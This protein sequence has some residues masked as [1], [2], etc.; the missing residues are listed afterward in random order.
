V[1][2]RSLSGDVFFDLRDLTS[3]T[4]DN[5]ISITIPAVTIPTIHT[6][7]NSGNGIIGGSLMYLAFILYV[8]VLY[9][10]FSSILRTL[11]TI[12]PQN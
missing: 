2:S 4:I 11:T 9:R 12:I 6:T 8:V 1:I 10:L 3:R 5:N 7:N